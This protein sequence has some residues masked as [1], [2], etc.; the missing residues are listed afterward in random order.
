LISSADDRTEAAEP[1]PQPALAKIG[2]AGGEPQELVPRLVDNVH[3]SSIGTMAEIFN[4]FSAP[5]K[6]FFVTPLI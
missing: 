5:I 1:V 6:I 3:T 2:C 4:E